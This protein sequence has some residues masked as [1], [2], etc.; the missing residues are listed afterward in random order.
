[1]KKFLVT[2]TLL[3]AAAVFSYIAWSHVQRNEVLIAWIKYFFEDIAANHQED[4]LLIGS[5]SLRYMDQS[6]HMQCG[7][8]LNRGIGNSDIPALRQYLSFSPLSISPELIV[9][10]AGENDVCRGA[11]PEITAENYIL[12]LSM[13]R[14]KYPES[15]LHVIAIKP[16]PA[17][18]QYWDGFYSVNKNV[19]AHVRGMEGTFFHPMDWDETFYGSPLSFVDDGVHL[20]DE[21]YIYFLKE[22][23]ELCK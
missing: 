16:S 20:T 8:W 4:G 11:P 9:V 14:N 13:L 6:R 5:S 3:I 10:Y 2:G 1:V 12:L 22:I 23:N 15:E 17:R 7:T 19:E 18:K 21:G